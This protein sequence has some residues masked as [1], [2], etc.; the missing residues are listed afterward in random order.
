MNHKILWN[1]LLYIILALL[2]IAR[3]YKIQHLY[4]VP[5]TH[6]LSN[7]Y[8]LDIYVDATNLTTSYIGG[9]PL[10]IWMS[11]FVLSFGLYSFQVHHYVLSILSFIPFSV[12]Y[13]RI[14][15]SNSAISF[16]T[17]LEFCILKLLSPETYYYYVFQ[18]SIFFNRF[19]KIHSLGIEYN[20]LLSKPEC[21]HGFLALLEAT[22]MPY[23][24][25]S[26]FTSDPYKSERQSDC[27]VYMHLMQYN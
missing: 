22:V 3:L 9:F 21:E 18:T 11:V 14:Y 2:P 24:V 7:M 5:T 19:C 1:V 16:N 10:L 6:C 27:S 8:V 4:G 26:R 12:P 25:T 15:M 23:S 17:N 13:I 20:I